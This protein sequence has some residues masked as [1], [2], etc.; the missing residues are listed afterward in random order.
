MDNSL[1]IIINEQLAN[2]LIW[3]VS[4]GFPAGCVLFYKIMCGVIKTQRDLKTEVTNLINTVGK[5]ITQ[6]KAD[7][8]RLE[9]QMVTL[10]MLKRIELFL[11]AMAKGERE[12]AMATAIRSEIEA[13]KK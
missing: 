3:A 7:V 5:D 1:G 11:L 6:L 10:E 12:D 4:V 13:R 9:N 8:V 2:I